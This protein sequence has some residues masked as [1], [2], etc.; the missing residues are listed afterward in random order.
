MGY[1]R[2]PVCE[3]GV[4]ADMETCYSCMYKFG[5]NPELEMRFAKS[6]AV[7]GECAVVQERKEEGVLHGESSRGAQGRKDGDESLCV[8]FLVQLQGFLRDFLLNSQVRVD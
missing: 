8:E 6:E 7:D 4:F 5:S 1:K 3:S 2:C